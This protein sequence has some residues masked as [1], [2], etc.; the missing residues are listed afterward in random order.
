MVGDLSGLSEEFEGEWFYRPV[1]GTV[2]Y[3]SLDS[4]EVDEL[5]DVLTSGVVV[6]LSMTCRLSFYS[7]IYISI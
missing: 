3:A 4:V 7:D 1:G 2:G 6:I 5:I